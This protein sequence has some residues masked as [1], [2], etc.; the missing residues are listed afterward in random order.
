MNNRRVLW[1][2]I[3]LVAAV[4]LTPGYLLRARMDFFR[5]KWS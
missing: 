1:G 3:L 2:I 5:M 4:L